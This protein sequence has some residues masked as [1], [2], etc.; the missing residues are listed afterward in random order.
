MNKNKIKKKHTL[1]EPSVTA[2]KNVDFPAEG[3]P[4]QPTISSQPG[5]KWD[6]GT[7]DDSTTSSSFS[8][9]CHIPIMIM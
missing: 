2:L 7:N 6:G 4:T 3:F 9:L 1:A 5:I 8:G